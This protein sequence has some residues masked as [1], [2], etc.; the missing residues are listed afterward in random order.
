[1]LALQ[2]N[3]E[4]LPSQLKKAMLAVALADYEL[5]RVRYPLTN[6]E[7]YASIPTNRLMFDRPRDERVMNNVGVFKS[8]PFTLQETYVRTSD[9][10]T[11]ATPSVTSTSSE[12][13]STKPVLVFSLPTETDPNGFLSSWWPVYM[14]YK[15]TVYRNA[16]QAIMAG[17][18]E[19][20]GK[21]DLAVTIR[22]TEQPEDI[23]LDMEMLP[24]AT[25]DTWDA[26]LREL[27]LSVT[28]EKFTAH[29]E[30]A[31]RLVQTGDALLGAVPPEDPTD[32]LLG[33]GLAL[34]NPGVNDPRKW[35]GQNVYGKAL[36]EVRESIVTRRTGMVAQEPVVLS[37]PPA[38]TARRR[39]RN[40]A[41]SAVQSVSNTAQEGLVQVQEGIVQ[42]VSRIASAV[43]EALSPST[44]TTSSGS[45]T[46]SS[47]SSTSSSGSSTSSS[48]SN[49]TSSG[50]ST[51]SSG[52]NTTSSGS[53]TSSS[54]SNTTS[55]GSNTSTTS[56]SPNLL[57]KL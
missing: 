1:M 53:S 43:T 42:T 16:Y 5:Q 10:E 34:E 11:S 57:R 55:S 7:M 50:S 13:V 32:T 24:E 36:E 21:E 46:S 20:F 29:P 44:T 12:E 6:V 45:N 56:V 39:L 33:I 14:T 19:Y 9:V 35:T 48:G 51:S 25:Q 8:R 26:K 23:S 27:V 18:A 31:E 49:T 38:K 4:T 17:L 37:I 2:E 52:S 47:G 15:G 28:Q 41:A 3:D 22:D 54:G 40:T 30:L